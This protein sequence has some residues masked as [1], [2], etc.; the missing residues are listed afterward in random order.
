MG[1]EE[2][3]KEVSRM[4]K[5]AGIIWKDWEDERSNNDDLEDEGNQ[6]DG[7]SIDRTTKDNHFFLRVIVFMDIIG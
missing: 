1:D 6:L 4:K 7:Y 3:D 2:H 5:M